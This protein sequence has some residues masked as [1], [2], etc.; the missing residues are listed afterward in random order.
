MQKPSTK[1]G[2]GQTG[3]QEVSCWP[4]L[5]VSQ[6]ALQT[7]WLLQSDLDMTSDSATLSLIDAVEA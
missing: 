3:L 4:M 6:S 1:Y 7:D 5:R 2:P